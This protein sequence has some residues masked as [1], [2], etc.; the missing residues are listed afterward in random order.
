MACA[1]SASCRLSSL[2]SPM[3]CGSRLMPT[4]SGSTSGAASNTRA[5]MPAWCRLSASASP[6]T[7]PPTIRT[8]GSLTRALLRLNPTLGHD[9]GPARTIAHHDLAQRRRCRGGGAEAL[10]LEYALGFRRVQDRRDLLVQPRNDLGWRAFGGEEAVP[11]VDIDALQSAFA[12]GRHVGKRRQ[13]F[14]TAGGDRLQL[15][16]ADVLGG[17]MDGQ[18]QVAD[19]AAQKILHPPPR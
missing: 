13:A 14:G 6:P 9:I 1:A 19:L 11:H 8:S 12:Q 10:R 17:D 7:P 2:S 3:A 5:E 4:P 16:G 15:A 18:E